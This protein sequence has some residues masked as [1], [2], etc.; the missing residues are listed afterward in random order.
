MNLENIPEYLK[1]MQAG[2][3]GNMKKEIIR[4]QRYLLIQLQTAMHQLMIQR[5]LHHSIKHLKN[6]VPMMGLG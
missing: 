3:Y 5:L 1:E 2:A 6:L 4:R